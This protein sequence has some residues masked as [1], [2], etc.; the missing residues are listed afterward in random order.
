MG[1]GSFFAREHWP[2]TQIDEEGGHAERTKLTA[3]ALEDESDPSSVL[4][5]G[6]VG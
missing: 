1:S 2:A 4:F 3:R 5:D 6:E